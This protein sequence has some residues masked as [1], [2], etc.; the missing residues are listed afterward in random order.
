MGIAAPA[1]SFGEQQNC[2]FPL[3]ILPTLSPGGFVRGKKKPEGG[4]DVKDIVTYPFFLSRALTSRFL[5][6]L[7]WN[8]GNV[9]LVALASNWGTGT[10][11]NMKLLS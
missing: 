9:D 1:G 8:T 5:Y 7:E 4:G 2:F 6:M 10:I 11:S 3:I